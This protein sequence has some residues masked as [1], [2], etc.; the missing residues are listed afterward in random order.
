MEITVSLF[1]FIFALA[2]I[3]EFVDASMGMGYGTILSPVLI[4]MGFDPVI[5]V[6]AILLSQAFGGFTAS[7]FHHQFNNVSFKRDSNDLKIVFVIV[8]FGIIAVIVAVLISVNISTTFLKTYIGALVI[9]MGIVLLWNRTFTFSWKKMVAVGIL[10]SF[11][12]AMSGGGF[13]PVVTGG[14][15]ISGQK[16]KQAVG[17]TTLAEA[18]IC[19]VAFFTYLI[20]RTIKEVDVPILEMPASEFFSMLFSPQLFQWELLLALLLGSIIVAP[21]AAFTTKLTKE[22]LHYVLGILMLILGLWTLY[23]TYC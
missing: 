4:I 21:F 20:V 10:S 1:L 18:P 13:G 7:F 16:P 12:K 6:P 15:I 23:K 22:K 2:F 8:G 5:A 17:V 19:I 3:C 14:Q 11:N 9:I